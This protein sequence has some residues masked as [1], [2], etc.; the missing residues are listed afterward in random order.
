M[1]VTED[2]VRL[3]VHLDEG[4]RV[5]EVFVSS[6]TK[7]R[8]IVQRLQRQIH[9]IDCFLLEVWQ[10][11]ERLVPDNESMLSTLLEWGSDLQDVRFYLRQRE[12][13]VS[14][15]QIVD[16]SSLRVNGFKE[17]PLPSKDVLLGGSRMSVDDLKEIAAR[18]QQ[19]IAIKERELKTKQ[20]QL[21]EIKRKTQRKP[22]SPHV[23]QL[24]AKVDEQSERLTA[25]RHA[26]DQ[27]DSYKLSN[28]AL[29]DELER[30]RSL[31][32]EKEKELAIAVAKVES[33]TRQLDKQ[34][35]GLC[36]PSS[37][38]SKTHQQLELERL[39]KELMTRNELNHQQSIQIQS[40]KQLL[41]E[42]HKELFEL[43]AQI[44]QH[45]EKLRKRTLQNNH[46][47][48]DNYPLYPSE[49]EEEEEFLE[50]DYG[51][52]GNFATRPNKGNS[53]NSK[54]G[55]VSV[56][57][58]RGHPRNSRKLETLLEVEEEVSD[59]NA[60]SKSSTEDL[61]GGPGPPEVSR[62]TPAKSRFEN[63]KSLGSMRNAPDQPYSETTANTAAIVVADQLS[64]GF[65]V[66]LQRFEPEGVEETEFSSS[67]LSDFERRVND[68]KEAEVY[69]NSLLKLKR[70]RDQAS[71]M[72]RKMTPKL[73]G[74]LSEQDNL[75]ETK[76]NMRDFEPKTEAPSWN[77]RHNN[78][79]D[80]CEHSSLGSPSSPS[81]LPSSPLRSTSSKAAIFAVTALSKNTGEYQKPVEFHK[82][83]NR[84]DNSSILG[85]QEPEE[86]PFKD[87]II[88]PPKANTAEP[89]PGFQNSKNTKTF[90]EE[91]F[92]ARRVKSEA[93]STKNESVSNN[94]DVRKKVCGST[95]ENP[96][97][98]GTLSEQSD[99]LPKQNDA[100]PNQNDAFLN[101]NDKLAKQSDV[102]NNAKGR[103]TDFS[104]VKTTVKSALT[105]K[106]N[107]SPIQYPTVVSEKKAIRLQTLNSEVPITR[108]QSDKRTNPK[109]EEALKKTASTIEENESKTALS[110]KSL[111]HTARREAF[112]QKGMDPL[113]TAASNQKTDSSEMQKAT[114]PVLS[115]TNSAVQ[116]EQAVEHLISKSPNNDGASD[117]AVNEKVSET[118]LNS[119]LKNNR[120][121]FD[122][123]PADKNVHPDIS[124]PVRMTAMAFTPISLKAKK[125][126]S[127]QGNDGPL[128]NR[129]QLAPVI[130]NSISVRGQSSLS[131][132]TITPSGTFFSAPVSDRPEKRSPVP[133]SKRSRLGQRF[134]APTYS[135][136]E[137]SKNFQ[138]SAEEFPEAKSFDGVTVANED[139]PKYE[140]LS[141][142]DVEETNSSE[143]KG[144]RK[145]SQ[146]KTQEELCR[147]P[148]HV[149]SSVNIKLTNHGIQEIKDKKEN[150]Q[151][152]SSF[153]KIIKPLKQ[154]SKSANGN[155][156][157]FL[158]TPSENGRA[159][160]GSSRPS[161]DSNGNNAKGANRTFEN[162]EIT[163]EIVDEPK[164][165]NSER[166]TEKRSKSEKLSRKVLTSRLS[167]PT[168]VDGRTI[169]TK[170]ELPTT[171]ETKDEM[172]TA[173]FTIG[174]EKTERNESSLQTL[175]RVENPLV[176]TAVEE[177]PRS[178][179]E[180]VSSKG[181]ISV[182]SALVDQA[183]VQKTKRS[184][185]A[186]RV[187]LD[188][189]AV[190]LDAAVE[191]ELDIVKEIVSE[192]E[193]P[194]KPNLEGITALH[195]AVCACHDDVVKFLVRYGCD[196][197]SR[198]SHGW[199]P[200]HCAAAN[201]ATKMSRFLVEHGACVLA[202]TSLESKTPGQCCE[203]S[204]P[205]YSDCT[206][207][208]TDVEQNLG[209]NNDGR[210]FTLY[211]YSANEEDEL[212]FECGEE[213]NVIRREDVA[214]KEWWWA[215]NKDGQTGY[216]PRNLLGLYPRISPKV[217]CP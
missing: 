56:G 132:I 194:S 108:L 161:S 79:S 150:I 207:Y 27:V 80:T 100:S 13:T 45:S 95:E 6:A 164:V 49:E 125:L 170:R 172:N 157:N 92:S 36:G 7:C 165:E 1:A 10:G 159:Q 192:L 136:E 118:S 3:K 24:S 204:E 83:D 137:E 156:S 121:E 81:S 206:R 176:P 149:V 19:E 124:P 151:I 94:S 89:I 215:V 64:N 14:F 71:E 96:R 146:G 162:R 16:G 180:N 50:M 138:D 41:A 174:N 154:E 86:V 158:Y 119:V 184:K 201:N 103:A 112:K 213:L 148:K 8:D 200:L 98:S 193:D 181:Y 21:M 9:A 144:D 101:Q 62:V 187:S 135:E 76:S 178:N 29:A 25:L 163:C 39:R 115:S 57:S 70:L 127:Q 185:K 202:A 110:L 40:Q 75:Q 22:Q 152:N 26:Q 195:N 143:E 166:T 179:A 18:Q 73:K 78:P 190:L 99:V 15:R 84:K 54:S 12:E 208:L 68:E 4:R 199:T 141:S 173:P 188:P 31:F 216:I 47:D 87:K 61:S 205:G 42:K 116:L 145:L 17:E 5:A 67:E 55:S 59:G 53:G 147:D 196:I 90:H 32:L 134:A 52:L 93:L 217:Q 43:D 97:L 23:Q 77:S 209:I 11:C 130:S 33:L 20:V 203:R 212:S 106:T 30:V 197:N 104:E 128:F 102:F 198:D 129:S 105:A 35:Q 183:P 46:T 126:A 142:E 74:N 155:V 65:S 91:I 38:Q 51:S 133:T 214:E 117:F 167:S 120:E 169:F 69:A 210:V 44:D 123:I 109:P 63:A 48:H 113:L 189:H 34:R 85:K 2:R 139:M 114:S 160:F 168:Q 175:E 131:K 72:D 37:S 191:G 107:S 111:Q 82:L 186:Q 28:S 122:R 182:D 66:S 153:G 211:S 88:Q 58:S 60:S 140:D 177:S 171:K